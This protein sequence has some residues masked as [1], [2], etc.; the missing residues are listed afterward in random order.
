[1]EW[2][3]RVAR[4]DKRRTGKKIFESKLEGSRRMGRP[5]LRW[6]GDVEKDVWEMKGKK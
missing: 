5:R 1:L 3:G 4:T 2:I 6:L